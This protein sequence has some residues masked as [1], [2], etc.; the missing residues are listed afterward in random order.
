MFSSIE[1]LPE[2]QQKRLKHSWAETFYREFFCRIDE[3]IFAVLYSDDAASRPNAPINVLVGLEVLKSGFGWSDEQLEEQLA[4][5]IQVRYALGYGDLS[6][7]VPQLR[8]VYNFR[9]RVSD[10]MQETGINL[11]EQVFEA[12]TDEQLTVLALK[13][14]KLRTDSTLVSSNIREMSRLQLLVEVLQRVWR[15]LSE[16]DQARYRDDF[17]GYLKGTSGQYTYRIA[18]GEGNTHLE[19]IGQLMRRL[20]DDLAIIVL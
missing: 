16:V 3:D 20:V 11:I 4:Y 6:E 15:L 1:D 5:N 12:V 9:R 17:E 18:S 2:K 10:Y 13:S 8:T 7:S 19:A 14:D